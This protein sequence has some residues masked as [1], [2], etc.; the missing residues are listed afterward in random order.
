M[1]AVH[2]ASFF[3]FKYFIKGSPFFSGKFLWIPQ[4][5]LEINSVYSVQQY[6]FSSISPCITTWAKH[7]ARHTGLT[8]EKISPSPYDTFQEELVMNSNTIRVIWIGSYK[9]NIVIING[10]MS[11]RP[12]EKYLLLWTGRCWRLYGLDQKQRNPQ[13]SKAG[14]TFFIKILKFLCASKTFMCK[15]FCS[16]SSPKCIICWHYLGH[17]ILWSALGQGWLI[18][19]DSRV[20]SPE[21][22]QW[23][24]VAKESC[25]WFHLFPFWTMSPPWSLSSLLGRIFF[26]LNLSLVRFFFKFKTVFL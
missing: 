22:A 1:E 18:S 9:L 15:R 8:D 20:T 26:F 13:S 7:C 14:D 12:C 6:T 25:A 5:Q 11:S 2:F 3:L 16:P 19:G 24:E 21:N 23:A 10:L 4:G 17:Y